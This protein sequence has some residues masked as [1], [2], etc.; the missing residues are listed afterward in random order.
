MA[1]R[2]ANFWSIVR[3]NTA[4]L[5]YMGYKLFGRPRLP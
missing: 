2:E 3:L 4:L 1:R 5:G